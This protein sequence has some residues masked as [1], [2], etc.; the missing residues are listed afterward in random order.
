MAAIFVSI[1]LLATSAALNVRPRSTRT[2]PY[3]VRMAGMS[4]GKDS[5]AWDGQVDEEA[6]LGLGDNGEIARDELPPAAPFVPVAP[7][8]VGWDANDENLDELVEWDLE[9][10]EWLELPAPVADMPAPGKVDGD[11]GGRGGFIADWSVDE[12]A[13]FDDDPD[14]E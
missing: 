8:P 13:Y 7:T 14:D 10:S 3:R 5:D 6:H 2:A 9:D 1:A 12:T 11:F 4:A